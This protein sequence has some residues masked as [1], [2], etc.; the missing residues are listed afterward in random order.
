MGR[1]TD[2]KEEYNDLAYKFCLLGA[3][4]KQM[5]GFFNVTEKTLNNWKIKYPRFLQSL[6]NGKEKADAEVAQALF[7]RAKGFKHPEVHVSNYKGEITLTPLIKHYA[8][9]TAAC[10]IWLKN[11]AGWKDSR[12][13]ENVIGDAKEHFKTIADAIALADTHSGAI[14]S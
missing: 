3:T 9:D 14:L 6:K 4:D 10:M 12:D 2:Y 1:K 8:A 11:R 13:T 7:H 5:A